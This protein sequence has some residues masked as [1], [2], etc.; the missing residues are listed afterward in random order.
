MYETEILGQKLQLKTLLK[1][2]ISFDGKSSS[3]ILRLLELHVLG[4]TL[5]PTIFLSLNWDVVFQILQQ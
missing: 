5:F 1:G 3:Y 2:Q 4:S